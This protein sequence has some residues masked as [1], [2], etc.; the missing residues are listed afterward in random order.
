MQ[1]IGPGGADEVMSFDRTARGLTRRELV[2]PAYFV[3]LYGHHG[4]H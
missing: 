3:R 4:Y 2:T 1:P